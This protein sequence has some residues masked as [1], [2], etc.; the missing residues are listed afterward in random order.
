MSH[1][2]VSVR[3]MSQKWSKCEKKRKESMWIVTISC[4][5]WFNYSGHQKLGF[6]NDDKMGQWV[7]EP[8]YVSNGL[9]TSRTLLLF[10]E[11]WWADYTWLGKCIQPVVLLQTNIWIS[12]I[13][14]ID[15][16]AHDALLSPVYREGYLPDNFY[17]FHALDAFHTYFVNSHQM[18]KFIP[19]TRWI[20]LFAC[21]YIDIKLVSLPACSACHLPWQDKKMDKPRRILWIC[22]CCTSNIT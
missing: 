1:S 10:V 8:E 9:Y 12:N 3:M 22:W 14:L 16:I 19:Q 6:P 5:S 11:I 17:F 21:N 18:H 4:I 7:G 13:I 2:G 20:R 15:S